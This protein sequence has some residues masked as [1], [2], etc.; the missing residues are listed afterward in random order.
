M[1]KFVAALILLAVALP[2]SAETLVGKTRAEL[3]QICTAPEANPQVSTQVLTAVCS[4]TMNVLSWT[5]TGYAP[6]DFVLPAGYEG[7]PTTA[8]EFCAAEYAARP[9]W[10]MSE[11]GGTSTLGRPD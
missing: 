7:L 6:K 4:C 11:F 2:V 8:F 1:K 9:A 10:F 5:I 3:N